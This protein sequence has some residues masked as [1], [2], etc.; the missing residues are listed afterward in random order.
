MGTLMIL[1]FYFQTS[2][3]ACKERRS[4][5]STEEFWSRNQLDSRD[6]SGGIEQW[7]IA[8]QRIGKHN[9]DLNECI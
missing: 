5:Q 8:R 3:Q 1:M 6:N 7:L 2:T 4:M 9:N